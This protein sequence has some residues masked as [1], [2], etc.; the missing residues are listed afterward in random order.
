MTYRTLISPKTLAA[1]LNDPDWAVVDCRFWLD[2][3]ERGRRDYRRAHIP[4]AVY[5]HLDEDLSAPPVPGQTGRHPLPDPAAFAERLGRWGIG[6]ATQVVAYDD[7]GGAIAARLWFLLRWLGHQAVAVLDGGYPRWVMERLPTTKRIPQPR[8]R[9][10]TPHLRPELVVATPEVEA[11]VR[12]ERAQ[13]L[14]D[15][16]TPERY[17]GEQEPIDPVA[18]HIPGAISLPYPDNL[19]VDGRFRP[20]EALRARFQRALQGQS[21]VFYC[22]SGVTAAH[23]LLA[24]L[25]AGLGEAPLYAG[26][27]S[28]WITDPRRPVATGE[29]P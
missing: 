20:P 18:G 15:S 12:G 19:T 21:P 25:H 28:E 6:N 22:G 16:R 11:I 26:S 9:T 27:W 29:Q 3:P 8:S 23:N 2:D 17:R 14:C 10:F 5:A 1:H 7:R 13:R 4:G 24:Y